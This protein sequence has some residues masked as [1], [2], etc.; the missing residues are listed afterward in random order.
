MILL[1]LI[2]SRKSVCI[3]R[4]GVLRQPPI[5]FAAIDFGPSYAENRASIAQNRVRFL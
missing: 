1:R 3:G 5:N 2:N 4:F